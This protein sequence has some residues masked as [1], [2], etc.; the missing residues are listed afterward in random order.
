MACLIV[1]VLTHPVLQISCYLLYNCTKHNKVL[2]SNRLSRIVVILDKDDEIESVAC[3]HSP[4][5]SESETYNAQLNR[6][7]QPKFHFQINMIKAEAAAIQYLSSNMAANAHVT[8]IFTNK[9]TNHFYVIC[10]GIS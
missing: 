3:S 4:D 6:N 10:N 7:I 1:L 5:Q 2:I 9:I 8:F